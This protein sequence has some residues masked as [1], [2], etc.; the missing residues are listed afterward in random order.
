MLQRAVERA[1]DNCYYTIDGVRGT[2]RETDRRSTCFGNEL[3]S[4]GVSKGCTV[5][6][7][8]NTSE[9][10]FTQWLGINKVGAIWVPV[11][12]AYKGEFLRH[13]ICDSLAQMVICHVE[14]LDRIVEIADQLPHVRKILVAGGDVPSGYR[15]PIWFGR[16]EDHR[17][18]DESQISVVIEPQDLAAL[19]YTSGTT[20]PSK[21]CMISHNYLCMQARQS[22]AQYGSGRENVVWTP[23]PMF[24]TSAMNVVLWG[25]FEAARISLSSRFSVTRFWDDVEASGATVAMLLSTILPLVAKSPDTAAMAR[26]KGQLRTVVGVPISPEIRQI[27]KTRFG[28]EWVTSWVYGQTENNRLTTALR[29]ESPPELS[30]G[31]AADE[32]DVMIFDDNDCPVDPGVV[33][34][35]VCRPKFPNVMFEGYW[36]RPEATALAW[37]NL[38]MHTG[39]LGKLDEQGWLF[40]V[41]RSKDYLRYK[42][43]NVSSFEVESVFMGHEAIA[44]AAV[45]AV[46]GRNAED[47]IKLTAVLKA[48]STI[49]ERELCLWAINKLPYFAVPKYFEFRSELPR[50]PAGRV[51]KYKLRDEGVT[52]DTWDREEAGLIVDRRS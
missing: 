32:F 17:G 16:F 30:C 40:F 33:G 2:F 6:T 12:L 39:D 51:L 35:I 26:C 34:H 20:G 36:N 44:E 27:W 13:Q 24:H 42:G 25:L 21:G 41:D 29:D 49:L 3:L 47:Q 37:R 7:I 31:R 22:S 4:L 8:M 19:L 52:A 10:L 23:L 11:N 14:Y 5:A 45:H 38:W 46:S 1:G 48:G 9:D 28:V 50:N 43:E 18:S 15:G